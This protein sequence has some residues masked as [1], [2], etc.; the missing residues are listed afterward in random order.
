[1]TTTAWKVNGV[2]VCCFFRVVFLTSFVEVMS[3][4]LLFF[5]L[6]LLLLLL[7]RFAMLMID[8]RAE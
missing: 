1:M 5:A 3:P 8:T 2:S 4:F 7:L 6:L